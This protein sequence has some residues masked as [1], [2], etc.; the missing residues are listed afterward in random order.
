[1]RSKAG[2]IDVHCSD[3]I[4]GAWITRGDQSIGVVAELG[5]LYV[6]LYDDTTTQK[7]PV[8]LTTKGI[9]IPAENGKVEFFE[10]SKLA[11]VLRKH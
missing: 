10:W 5:Q 4:C 3:K 1:M 9:Q 7:V 6:C 11:E 2:G 8:A